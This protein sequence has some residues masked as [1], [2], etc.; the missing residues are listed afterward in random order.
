M[1]I[2]QLT[3]SPRLSWAL[4]GKSWSWDQM[5]KRRHQSL[6][7]SSRPTRTPPQSPCS[8]NPPEQHRL[9][10]DALLGTCLTVTT[11]TME[12]PERWTPI[13]W[14]DLFLLF[15]MP[16][17]TSLLLSS[18]CC[19]TPSSWP[20]QLGEY[21]P[22]FTQGLYEGLAVI[23]FISSVQSLHSFSSLLAMR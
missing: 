15:P 12:V 9:R 22:K 23:Y 21:P 2:S 3:F 5:W 7:G 14:Q 6:S 17:P 4:P 20:L 13:S 19:W 1:Y 18:T 8:S 11:R 16:C 10:A